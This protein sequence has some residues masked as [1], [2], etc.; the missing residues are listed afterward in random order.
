MP[1]IKLRRQLLLRK[2]GSKDEVKDSVIDTDRWSTH[3]EFIFDHNG[4]VYR[5]YYK[6]G[7]TEMQDEQPW[8]FEDMVDCHE[9]EQVEVTKYEWVSVKDAE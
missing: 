9:V 8:E 5:T 6:R 1:T 2:L 4:K 3:Y 7:S